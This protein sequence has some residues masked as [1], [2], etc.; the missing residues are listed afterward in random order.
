MGLEGVFMK[1]RLPTWL[2]R[3]KESVPS[4]SEDIRE[5]LEILKKDSALESM[6]DLKFSNILFK[7]G[8]RGHMVIISEREPTK[9]TSS[10]SYKQHMK[11]DFKRI[12]TFYG[13][14]AVIYTK[15]NLNCFGYIFSL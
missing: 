8:D 2:K 3:K 10:Y 6:Y 1:V 12:D 14:E 5:K 9:E 15:T 13:M 7:S 4:I 11:N